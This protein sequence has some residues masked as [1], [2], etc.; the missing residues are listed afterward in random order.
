[1]IKKNIFA[2]VIRLQKT[3][4][5]RLGQDQYIRLGHTSSGSIQDIFETFSKLLQNVFKTSLRGLAKTT[6]RHLQDVLKRY[7]QELFKTYHQVKLFLFTS[8]RDVFN[9][10]L[11]RTAKTVIRR[12]FAY[13][14]LLGNL[15]SVYKICKSDKNFSSFSFS[16]HC[17]F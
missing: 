7:F 15:W 1:M 11:R 5:R 10:F 16:L 4:S 8:L 14:T 17:N 2:L 12:R 9:T 6:S 13:V 3:S